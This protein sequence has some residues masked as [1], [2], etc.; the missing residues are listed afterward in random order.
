MTTG[1]GRETMKQQATT[2][3]LDELERL[4]RALDWCRPRLSPAHRMLLDRYRSE[5]RKPTP[6]DFLPVV[7]SA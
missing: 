3:E 6:D 2:E 5:V 1:T 7:T 4:N